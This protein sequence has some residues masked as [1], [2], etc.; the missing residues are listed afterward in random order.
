MNV[1]VLTL[2][3]AVV[4]VTQSETMSSLAHNTPIPATGGYAPY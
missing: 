2:L 1:K 3:V 4:L